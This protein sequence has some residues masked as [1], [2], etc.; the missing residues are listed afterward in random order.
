MF[1]FFNEKKYFI[2]LFNTQKPDGVSKDSSPGVRSGM[3]SSPSAIVNS[4]STQ[5]ASPK[6][7]GSAFKPV[8]G[9][10]GDSSQKG[11]KRVPSKYSSS[12]THFTPI[13]LQQ[14]D[15][16]KRATKTS[17]VQKVVDD[18]K[19]GESSRE[20]EVVKK[21]KELKENLMKPRNG[22]NK[23][24]EGSVE[25]GSRTPPKK[26]PRPRKN[27]ETQVNE[28]KTSSQVSLE[29]IAHLLQNQGQLAQL[30]MLA[31]T[32]AQLL[33]ASGYSAR[34]SPAQTPVSPHN[35]SF[36][37]PGHIPLTPNMRLPSLDV[38]QQYQDQLVGR[39]VTMPVQTSS[40]VMA[41]YPVQLQLQQDPRT[42]LLQL[43]PIGMMPSPVHSRGSDVD[44]PATLPRR[45]ARHQSNGG[46]SS[47]SGSPHVRSADSQ[48]SHT[49]G[50]TTR[51]R[52]HKSRSK[53]CSRHGPFSTSSR[54]GSLRKAQSEH[55]LAQVGF[56]EDLPEG[57]PGYHPNGHRSGSIPNL[58]PN[59]VPNGGQVPPE[60]IL[61]VHEDGYAYSSS[62]VWQY[63]A[64]R[65][66]RKHRNADGVSQNHS[67]GGS[68][69]RL[70]GAHRVSPTDSQSSSPSP[71]KDS[72]VSGVN[73]GGVNGTQGYNGF[74]KTDATLMDRLLGHDSIKQQQILQK[75][76]ALLR[77]AFA[78][79]GCL[80]TGGEDYVMGECPCNFLIC[81]YKKSCAT[82]FLLQRLA[83][84]SVTMF[85]EKKAQRM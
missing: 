33:Q 74:P 7:T 1:S 28:E 60:Y 63:G 6:N 64:M 32:I 57:N 42:G 29:T 35:T 51:D 52:I 68:A 41:N 39:T 49:L 30:N 72:G 50:R 37:T 58:M 22:Q 56:E 16:P 12:A 83:F 18:K 75:V 27:N 46:Y 26:P 77:Q 47:G 55:N 36:Q 17:P 65:H 20:T 11:I 34:S 59:N 53:E 54:E 78:D 38:P 14:A 67:H 23:E 85:L 24:N 76:V 62:P 81:D 2:I 19:T 66:P 43:V 13:I 48:G 82:R 79:D 40:N 70:S 80:E 44:S 10:G 45:G 5:F 4:P 71:S 25:T 61:P 69:Q 3:E 21:L 15:T 31:A 73:S 8:S 84:L 9:P